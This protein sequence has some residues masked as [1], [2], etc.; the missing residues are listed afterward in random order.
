MEKYLKKHGVPEQYPIMML[1]GFFNLRWSWPWEMAKGHFWKWFW[2]K[3]RYADVFDDH[4]VQVYYRCKRILGIE[5]IKMFRVEPCQDFP[6]PTR[7]FTYNNYGQAAFESNSHIQTIG[8]PT[9]GTYPK[10]TKVESDL[11]YGKVWVDEAES[12]TTG[13]KTGGKTWSQT[14]QFWDAMDDEYGLFE[15]KDKMMQ[16]LKSIFKFRE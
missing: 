8:Y 3:W 12:V 14:V 7:C 10:G 6:R 2:H 5:Y 11:K 4:K 13:G 16:K 9:G 15:S 1:T